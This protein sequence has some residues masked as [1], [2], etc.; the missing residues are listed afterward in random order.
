MPRDNSDIT[1]H[2]TVRAATVIESAKVDVTDAFILKYR[3]VKGLNSTEIATL[4]G[5]TPN[6]V[7]VRLH[8]L[9]ERIP[10]L[11]SLD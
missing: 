10:S 6:A 8:R 3:H 1:H 4:A 7:R 5:M 2:V 11:R 9:R